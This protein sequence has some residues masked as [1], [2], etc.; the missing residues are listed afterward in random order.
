MD[1]GRE[2]QRTVS[3]SSSSSSSSNSS[4]A[5]SSSTAHPRRLREKD[6][7]R[8]PSSHHSQSDKV[9]DA[10]LDERRRAKDEKADERPATAEPQLTAHR[11][12][13]ERVGSRDEAHCR[14]MGEPKP[15]SSTN[16]SNTSKASSASTSTTSSRNA[17]PRLH[18]ARKLSTSSSRSGTSGGVNQPT[19]LLTSLTASAPRPPHSLSLQSAAA[20]ASAGS[21][22]LAAPI[23][24]SVYPTPHPAPFA[25]PPSNERRP[26]AARNLFT[27]HTNTPTSSTP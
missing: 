2:R 8:V 14:R 5:S 27:Q 19:P 13:R 6:A 7:E 12:P 4:S 24:Q 21:S 25:S 1:K 18:S 26:Q 9:G 23:K 3:S 22:P 17:S 11:T 20:P 10:V 16:S 15:A